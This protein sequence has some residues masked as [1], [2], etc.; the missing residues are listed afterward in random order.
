MSNVEYLFTCFIGGRSL[1]SPGDS[2]FKSVSAAWSSRLHYD[3]EVLLYTKV[4]QRELLK[5]AAD[6]ALRCT[7]EALVTKP[8]KLTAEAPLI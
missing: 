6:R 2:S 1:L 4:N 3:T 8:L 5:E 7:D